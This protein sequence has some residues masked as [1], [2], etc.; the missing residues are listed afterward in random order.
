MLTSTRIAL[1]LT[2]SAGCA[3]SVAAC[4]VE[5][6]IE[7]EIDCQ[8]ICDRY[9]DCFDADYDVQSCQNRCEN[10]VDSG[11]LTFEEVDACSD[12]IDDRSCASGTLS[13]TTECLG[14]VP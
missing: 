13:C 3:L 6:E 12:C 14:I 8:S 10:D 7:N 1:V 9:S 4:G 2:L 11:D 5:K